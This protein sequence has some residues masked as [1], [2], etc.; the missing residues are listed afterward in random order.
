MDGRT[1]HIRNTSTTFLLFIGRKNVSN[2]SYGQ[3]WDT[4][5]FQC[6]FS[7]SVTGLQIILGRLLLKCMGKSRLNAPE[8]LG[9]A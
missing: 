7:A 9:D 6:T 5:C 3:K 4:S 8:I 2:K 1:L